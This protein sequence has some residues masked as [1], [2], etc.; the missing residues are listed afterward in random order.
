MLGRRT[1]LVNPPLING[2]AF[3]RQ[4]RCQER[5]EVL[6]TTKPPY[7]LALLAAMLRNAG[8][9]VRLVDA[10]A[11]R[12]TTEQ[13]IASVERDGFKPTLILFPSTTPTLDADVRE[14]A[15]LKRRFGA[16]MFC[17]GPHASTVP[18]NSMERA[19]DVDGMFVGEPEDGVMQ[20]SALESLDR[21]GE[22][23]SLTWRAGSDI[24]PHHAH[25]AFSGTGAT[26]P[27]AEAGT[28]KHH[29]WSFS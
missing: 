20:L 9:E 6:G 23:P 3:T 17:F 8:C 18:S 15:K 12:S 1:L 5:E 10:T 25:G 21:L 24:Y 4:G 14:M 26:S 2:V 28:S 29:P 11:T 22:V 7:T 19:P 27:V 13:I 16:P